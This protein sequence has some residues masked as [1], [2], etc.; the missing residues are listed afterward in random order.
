MINKKSFF[1]TILC[2]PAVFEIGFKASFLSTNT[3]SDKN[4]LRPGCSEPPSA[5]SR[6]ALELKQSRIILGWLHCHKLYIYIY[7]IQIIFLNVSASLHNLS[8]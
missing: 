3:E 2:L 4:N 6:P 8:D 7:Q 5:T 1:N